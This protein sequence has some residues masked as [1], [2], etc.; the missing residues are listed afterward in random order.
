MTT[1]TRTTRSAEAR[2]SG[3]DKPKVRHY[4][5]LDIMQSIFRSATRRE[6]LGGHSKGGRRGG[7]LKIDWTKPLPA[8]LFE[9]LNGSLSIDQ[10]QL[11]FAEYKVRV[12]EEK[13]RLIRIE[14]YGPGSEKLSDSQRQRLPDSRERTAPKSVVAVWK[15]AV[16]WLIG[17]ITR[18]RLLFTRQ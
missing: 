12:L 7:E 16:Q 14:K 18:L 5:E 2:L 4:D 9:K 13:L 8:A 3:G 1:V 17:K 11:K 10:D 6:T 15:F